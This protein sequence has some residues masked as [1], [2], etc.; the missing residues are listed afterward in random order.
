MNKIIFFCA[1]PATFLFYPIGVNA[2]V[3]VKVESGMIY[4]IDG[5]FNPN[6]KKYAAFADSLDRKLKINDRDTT[7][8]FFRSLLYLSFNG[9]KAKPFPAEKGALEN[10]I[11]AKQ[12][13]EKAISLKMRN[14]NLKVLHAQIYRELT[15]R[16]T[17]DQA[18]QYSSKQ[19]DNRR[20]QFNI[21]KE[22]A[23]K[24]YSELAEIDKPNA[25]D[26]EKLKVKYNY[27]L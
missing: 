10:L 1:L 13:A 4:I 24:Y 6:P 27:P 11:A 14:F 22:L 23:N 7:S 15:Y 2:Q 5:S 17:S 19:V 8:L 3:A 18:W 21:Y 12:L 26:Y 16:F 9:L 25:N 20:K